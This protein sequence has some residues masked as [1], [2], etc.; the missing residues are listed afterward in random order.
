M[1]KRIVALAALVVWSSGA[2]AQDVSGEKVLQ[3]FSRCRGLETPV[4]QL[5]CFQNAT[6]ALE[7]AVKTKDVT[8]LDRQDIRKARRSLFGFTL[9]RIGLFSR[10]DR[11]SEPD[12]RQEFEELNTSIA[13]LRQIANGRVEMRL[14]EDDAVWITTDPMP[15]PPKPGAKIRIRKGALGNYFLM[16]EGSRSVRGVRLR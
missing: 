5:D 12:D 10:G 3:S 16:A 15:F 7:S 9:P 2:A 14:A 11:D 6:S 4:A 1:F 13:S 8:I